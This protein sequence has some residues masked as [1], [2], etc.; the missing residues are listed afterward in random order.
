M[1]LLHDQEF[2]IA[3]DVR[4]V[5]CQ[6]PRVSPGR[7]NIRSRARG[8]SLGPLG[9]HSSVIRPSGQYL[10][11]PERNDSATATKSE[12]SGAAERCAWPRVWGLYPSVRPPILTHMK[13]RL[14][15]APVK[16][17][18]AHSG[19][20]PVLCLVHGSLSLLSSS[21]FVA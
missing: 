19:I 14:H 16:L 13:A 5:R 1:T 4:N 2:I 8:I 15:S 9:L 3:Q 11:Q 21:A 18:D 17:G 6:R 7:P 20:P 10:R 12:I